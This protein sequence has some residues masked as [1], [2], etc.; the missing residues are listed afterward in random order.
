MGGDQTTIP[1]HFLKCSLCSK[2]TL[3]PSETREGKRGRDD[4]RAQGHPLPSGWLGQEGGIWEGCV[5]ASGGKAYPSPSRHLS[6]SRRT[7]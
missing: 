1:F 2:L 6:C 3:N 7:R 4:R 5:N